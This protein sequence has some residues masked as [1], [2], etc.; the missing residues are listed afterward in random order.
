VLFAEAAP[1]CVA[2]GIGPVLYA[3]FA[4]IRRDVDSA[5]HVRSCELRSCG[6]MGEARAVKSK[7]LR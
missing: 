3:H 6:K 4:H 1:S 5:H 7:L 2:H